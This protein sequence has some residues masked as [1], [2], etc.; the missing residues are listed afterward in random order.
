MTI[1][2]TPRRAIGYWSDGSNGTPVLHPRD[3]VD[4]SWD[5]EEKETVVLHLMNGAAWQGYM[6]FAQCRICG[7]LLGTQDMTDGTYVWPEKLE[8]YL[9]DHGVRLPHEFVLHIDSYHAA[10]E[11]IDVDFS[12]WRK[13]SSELKGAC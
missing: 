9:V 1:D 12:W 13:K 3:L 8:H 7:E 2:T 5:E 4:P 10:I 6:G 11:E